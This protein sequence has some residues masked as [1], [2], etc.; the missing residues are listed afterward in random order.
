MKAR[1]PTARALAVQP[2]VL[3]L[4]E[5]L[6][7]LDRQIR[8][9]LQRELAGLLRELK[10]TALL[11][12][13]DQEEAFAMADRVAIMQAGKLEQIDTPGELYRWPRTEF[14]ATFLGAG[15]LLDAQ[16]LASDADGLACEALG[17]RFR[18][19]SRVP[20]TAGAV[21]VLIRPEQLQ[22]TRPNESVAPAWRGARIAEVL[23]SSEITRYRLDIAGSTLESVALGLPRF[24]P[25]ETVDCTLERDG[26]VV[27]G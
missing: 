9:R 15:T 18:S 11:V 27:I 24:A 2:A 16:C 6:G 10:M 13:H 1:V 5:P 4:D 19:R 17:G 8:Q 25:G 23:N 21:R 7:A 12:T 14:V 22:I 3:L 20:V 26:P